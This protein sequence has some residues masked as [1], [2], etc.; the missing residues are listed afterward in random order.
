MKSMSKKILNPIIIFS[1]FLLFGISLYFIIIN[2]KHQSYI[3]DK[4]IVT[5]SDIYLKDYKKN[6]DSILDNLNT[7]KDTK[8]TYIDDYEKINSLNQKINSCY[9]HL[10]SNDTIY[11]LSKDQELSYVDIYNYANYVYNSLINDCWVTS[12]VKV[13]ND[14]YQASYFKRINLFQEEID[15]ILYNTKN[16]KNRLLSNSLYSFG[17]NDSKYMIYNPLNE[18]YNEMTKIYDDVSKIVL[19][20]SNYLV[21]GEDYE[22]F[23]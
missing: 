3:N 7:Y 22:E 14:N 19:D 9:I 8:G 12:L 6:V 2:Y 16:L 21:K 15:M 11:S 18:S 4:Y 17:S 13:K 5:D 10:V 1:C 20:F 23:N